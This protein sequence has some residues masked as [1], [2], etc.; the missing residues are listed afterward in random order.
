MKTQEEVLSKIEQWKQALKSLDNLLLKTENAKTRATY[1]NTKTELKDNI[2]LL[3]W[4][5]Y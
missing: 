2:K 1:L 3:E 5:V 4:V